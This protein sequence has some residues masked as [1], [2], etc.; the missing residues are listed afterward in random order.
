[1]GAGAGPAAGGPA[2][3]APAPRW[4]S[5]S[6]SSCLLGRPARDSQGGGASSLLRVRDGPFRPDPWSAIELER[7]RFGD[8]AAVPVAGVA[9]RTVGRHVCVNRRGRAERDMRPGS[10]WL[11]RGVGVALLA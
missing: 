11:G 9:R 6:F 1:G 5:V 8:L 3:R 4:R 2:S 10:G 7:R